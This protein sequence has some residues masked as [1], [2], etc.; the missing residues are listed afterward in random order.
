[1][2]YKFASVKENVSRDG[3]AGIHFRN[4]IFMLFIKHK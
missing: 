1:M 2:Q 3:G 4:N